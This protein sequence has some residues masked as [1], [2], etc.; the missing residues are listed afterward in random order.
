MPEER[1]VRTRE[2]SEETQAQGAA[3]ARLGA[4]DRLLRPKTEEAWWSASLSSVE[5]AETSERATIPLPPQ[6]KLEQQRFEAA[7]VAAEKADTLRREMAK[8]DEERRRVAKAAASVAVNCVRCGVRANEAPGQAFSFCTSCGADLPGQVSTAAP[9]A[10]MLPP[11]PT[12]QQGF[13]SLSAATMVGGTMNGTLNGTATAQRGGRVEPGVAATLSFFVPGIGQIMNGQVEKGI[14][15]LLGLYVAAF[16]FGLP[17][18]GLPMLLA[19]II[20]S[21]DSYRIAQR[22]RKGQLVRSGEW[23]IS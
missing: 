16:L 19:R 4:S 2:E 15:L 20:V 10:R 9:T 13:T 3:A 18:F 14:L 12:Q 11:A 5:S 1:G 17:A 22:K 6:I 8:R 7:R 23:D 21:I